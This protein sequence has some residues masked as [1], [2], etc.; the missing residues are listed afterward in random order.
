MGESYT[1]KNPLVKNCHKVTELT[2]GKLA[3]PRL[4]GQEDDLQIVTEP[5][6]PAAAVSHLSFFHFYV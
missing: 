3:D 6:N 4:N 1:Q 5:T 2:A